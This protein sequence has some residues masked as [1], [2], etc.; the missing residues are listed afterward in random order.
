MSVSVAQAN[1]EA[2]QLLQGLFLTCNYARHV[3]SLQPLC[4]CAILGP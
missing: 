1:P 3:A 4:L 2:E